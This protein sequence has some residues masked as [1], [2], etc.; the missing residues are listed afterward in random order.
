MGTFYL[1]A[2]EAACEAPPGGCWQTRGAGRP[3]EGSGD[4]WGLPQACRLGRS[5]TGGLGRPVVMKE[6]DQHDDSPE[7]PFPH[8]GPTLPP[9]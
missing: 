5:G 8:P 2:P 7:P 3:Q 4:L 9:H 6:A 1:E